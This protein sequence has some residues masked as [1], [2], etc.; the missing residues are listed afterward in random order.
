MSRVVESV[1][2]ALL[3]SIG[4]VSDATRSSIERAENGMV[5]VKCRPNPIETVYG[6]EL[7]TEA[8]IHSMG[9]AVSMAAYH[10]LEPDNFQLALQTNAFTKT[11]KYS[12]KVG[13]EVLF[14][15]NAKVG[16]S[17]LDPILQFDAWVERDEGR[18]LLATGTSSV[19]IQRHGRVENVPE[20]AHAP[21]ARIDVDEND[22]E[23]EV[24]PEDVAAGIPGVDASDEDGA[25]GAAADTPISKVL[26]D[27][28]VEEK[29]AVVSPPSLQKN[30]STQV[31][32]TMVALQLKTSSDARDEDATG[33]SSGAPRPKK[34]QIEASDDVKPATTDVVEMGVCEGPLLLEAQL[35]A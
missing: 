24:P 11:T 31:V 26:P 27:V 10:S 4:D 9:H 12:P 6:E 3:D 33:T 19:G 13:E 35:Q 2:E 28:S 32:Q 16:G 21:D 17:I 18:F 7:V 8:A 1:A 29:L 5:I 25:D 23:A 14:V 20:I 30:L 15:G 34:K 22:V